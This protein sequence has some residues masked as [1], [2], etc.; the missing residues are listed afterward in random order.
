M[1]LVQLLRQDGSG[2]DVVD[3]RVQEVAGLFT[4]VGVMVHHTAGPRLHVE[5]LQRG[6]RFPGPLCNIGIDLDAARH[7]ITDGRANDSGRGSSVVLARVR[8]D[9]P[10][11][12]DARELGLVDD[13]D[14]N[15]WYYDIEVVNDGVGQ[16]YPDV[17]IASLVATCAALCRAHGWTANRVI[18]H[19]EHTRRKVDMS[20]RGDVRGRVRRQLQE[21]AVTKLDDEDVQRIADALADRLM[22]DRGKPLGKEIDAIRQDVR[23]LVQ[24]AGGTPAS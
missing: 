4:P 10:P 22:P 1:D 5:G 20:Y 11:Q 9:L 15:R 21:D 17:Q 6:Y 2:F 23:W 24:N 8:R 12:G 16:P 18:H 19:R 7:V 14:G 13:I 3:D